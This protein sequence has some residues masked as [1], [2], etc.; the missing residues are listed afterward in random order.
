MIQYHQPAAPQNFFMDHDSTPAMEEATAPDQKRNLLTT[1]RTHQIL[2]TKL[3]FQPL[4]N[5]KMIIDIILKWTRKYIIT[6]RIIYID[7]RIYKTETDPK[8]IKN[9]IKKHIEQWIANPITWYNIDNEWEASFSS[10]QISENI[11]Q[12]IYELTSK[13]ITE[14]KFYQTVKEIKK[15][16]FIPGPSKINYKI[17]KQMK[18]VT[19][20]YL[21]K[22]INTCITN[23]T[24]PIS[25]ID[26]ELI[27]L[28]K[29][30]DWK[31]NLNLTRSIILL[32]T[33]WKIYI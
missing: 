31:E 19:C 33:F 11:E 4:S 32:D 29:P 27:L 24:T 17:I 20:S 16:N 7:D 3:T 30:K 21:I 9:K 22:F 6:D 14:D 12:M 13:L 18:H 15:G 25:W 5:L 10:I 8:K 26:S 1:K 28:P 23:G 2:Y